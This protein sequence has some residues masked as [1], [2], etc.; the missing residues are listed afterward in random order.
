MVIRD[1]QDPIESQNKTVPTKGA[2]LGEAPPLAAPTDR[3]A[4]FVIDHFIILMPFV[5]LILAPFQRTMKESILFDN[6]W[7]FSESIFW[8]ALSVFLVLILFQTLFVWLWGGTPGKAL[9][10]LR[11]QNVW[12]GKITLQQSFVRAFYWLVSCAVF[13]IPFLSTFSNLLRRPLHDRI[14]DTVVVSLRA[15][16]VV[17]SPGLRESGLV[18]GVYGS[19][20]AMLILMLGL[21]AYSALS[22]WRKQKDLI[23]DLES[24]E[25]VCEAVSHAIEDWPTFQSDEPDRLEVAMSLYAAGSISLKCLQGE[26]EQLFPD[27]ADSAILN[28]ARS[29]I[30]SD[31]SELSDSYL[32]AVCAKYPQSDECHFSQL[33][34][35]SAEKDWKTVDKEAAHFTPQTPAYISI[36]IARQDVLREDFG[37]AREMLARIPDSQALADLTAPMKAKILWALGQQE[38]ALGIESVAY[39]WL[40]EEAQI[41]LSSF[42]CFE[43]I[44]SDCEQLKSRSC[45]RFQ[46]LAAEV[47]GSLAAVKSSLAYLRSWECQQKSRLNYETLITVPMNA[48]VKNIVMALNEKGADS[49]TELTN[50]ES[51]DEEVRQES[52]RRMVERTKNISL[53]K[54]ISKDW[55]Q[56]RHTLAWRK[57]GET[58]FRKFYELQEYGESLSVAEN[59]LP[60]VFEKS[61][62]KKIEE[63]AVV[64]ALKIGQTDR[65]KALFRAYAQKYPLPTDSSG[66]VPAST[67][68][69]TEAVRILTA[70]GQ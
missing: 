49:F 45:E 24:Q 38:E 62:L 42:L 66:R 68:D 64:A 47:D 50:D 3:M 31:H 28:L 46:K 4:A 56:S 14:S 54:L 35:A 55:T 53:L 30:Y 5:Y 44:W 39:S 9:L 18:D 52:S 12:G 51:L 7:R 36:W 6:Q 65:A 2:P 10:G 37:A 41:E 59:L 67:S 13:G 21:M 22:G 11:V 17:R 40:N 29:F 34:S 20:G 43:R 25:I 16:R 48:E 15:G 27:S 32:E 63:G 8:A 69:F 26:V 58:L 23:S 1:S 33:I 60:N 61:L 19:V 70:K 57:V